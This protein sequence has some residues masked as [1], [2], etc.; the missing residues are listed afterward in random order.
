MI[1]TVSLILAIAALFLALAVH[2]GDEL[3][4]ALA[5]LTAIASA[6]AISIIAYT[7]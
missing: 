5:G 1:F 7:A 6:L 3:C 2:D 4:T